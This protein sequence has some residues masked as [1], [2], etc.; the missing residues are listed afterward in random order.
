M[1][2]N[3]RENQLD[4]AEG[5]GNLGDHVEHRGTYERLQVLWVLV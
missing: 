4:P 2:E 1:H 5:S 3:V